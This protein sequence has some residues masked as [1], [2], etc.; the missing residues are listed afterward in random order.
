MKRVVRTFRGPSF[1]RYVFN[2]AT[3]YSAADLRAVV[4]AVLRYEKERGHVPRVKSGGEVHVMTSRVKR[5]ATLTEWEIVAKH[6][7]WSAQCERWHRSAQSPGA[8]SQ[9]HCARRWCRWLEQYAEHRTQT[10]GTSDLCDARYTGRA[11]LSGIKMVLRVPRE[12]MS[13]R[14]FVALTRHEVWHLCGIEHRDMPPDVMR[15]TSTNNEHVE[16]IVASLPEALRH[17]IVVPVPVPK[18]RPDAAARAAARLERVDARIAAWERR[19]T[20]AERALQRLRAKRQRLVRAPG[21]AA[22][23][24]V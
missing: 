6:A 21:R 20:R 19:L 3:R 8:R 11:W 14:A 1:Y 4:D 2:N 9:L 7:H 24:P 18:Q 17:R 16:E 15:C 22:A 23:R 10:L 12:A 13:T 5:R